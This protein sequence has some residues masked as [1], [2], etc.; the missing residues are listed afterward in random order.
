MKSILIQGS[1]R[2]QG[3]T[4]KILDYFRK[5]F[6]SDLVDLKVHNIG[7]FEYE[8]IHK[9]DDFIPLM[10]KLMNYDLWIFASPVYWYSMSGLMKNFFDRITD[11]LWWEK[12]LEEGMKGK[13]MMSIACSS[14]EEMIPVFFAPF[15]MSAEYLGMEYWGSL[16]A[17]I[18]EEK[19]LEEACKQRIDTFIV[20]LKNRMNT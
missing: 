12:E 2:S 9:D 18:G 5:N 16:H 20:E 14:D 13:K 6:E 3:N 19:R 15:E 1:S 4:S 11:C 8:N 10:H 7:L 17:W